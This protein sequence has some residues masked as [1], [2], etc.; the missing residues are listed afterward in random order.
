MKRSLFLFL[1][2]L[3]GL[4]ICSQDFIVTDSTY[5]IGTVNRNEFISPSLKYGSAADG[6]VMLEEGT[7]LFV[8]GASEGMYWNYYDVIY[9][10]KVYYIEKTELSFPDNKDYCS[11]L[12]HL[13][14][15]SKEK[16]LKNALQAGQEQYAE[17]LKRAET[18][19][20][21][22]S[23]LGLVLLDYCSFDASEYTEGTN[24][25]V[26]LMN[27]TSK[28][29]KYIWLAFVGYN[30]V[31]DPVRAKNGSTRITLK[32]IGP[33]AKGEC[34]IYTFEYVWLNDI[35]KNAK[36]VN[37]KVQYMDGTVRDIPNPSK[38]KI[39]SKVYNYVQPAYEEFTSN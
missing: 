9:R 22:C 8:S 39:D 30:A 26:R 36:I 16:L 28:T 23:K 19:Y 11:T 24:A 25:Q 4:K 14:S 27:P 33:L 32:C 15:D 38:I 2:L 31:N 10:G 18:F 7:T 20:K 12:L 29:I 3:V 1:F 34:A 5:L 21:E 35:V 13:D 37:V 17:M 6:S